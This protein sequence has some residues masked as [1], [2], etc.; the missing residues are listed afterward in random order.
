MRGGRERQRGE[1]IE[2]M[3]KETEGKGIERRKRETEGGGN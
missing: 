3:K 1:E 2:R